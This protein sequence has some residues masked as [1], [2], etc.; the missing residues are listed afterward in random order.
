M[1]SSLSAAT[2]C[3]ANGCYISST[4]PP[5]RSFLP[6]KYECS[7]PWELFHFKFLA[8]PLLLSFLLSLSS[9]EQNSNTTTPRPRHCSMDFICLSCLWPHL[10]AASASGWVVFQFSPWRHGDNCSLHFCA[11][12][13][14]LQISHCSCS[15]YCW[16]LWLSAGCF[17]Y[18]SSLKPGSMLK[19]NS[20]QGTDV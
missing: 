3:T 6:C 5:F 1:I 9:P 4:V 16:Y 14:I 12:W 2:F 17:H 20:E 8:L 10:D 18:Q 11:N 13:L 19:V 15:T 7:C